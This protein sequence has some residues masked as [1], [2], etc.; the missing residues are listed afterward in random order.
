MPYAHNA[1][2]STIIVYT[3]LVHAK[4]YEYENYKDYE[5]KCFFIASA[6][7]KHHYMFTSCDSVEANGVTF[8]TDRT[9]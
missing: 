7:V 2:V 5:N 6:S 1:I 4:A 8:R 3:S 9:I